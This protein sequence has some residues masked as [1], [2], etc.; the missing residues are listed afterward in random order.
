M[1]ILCPTAITTRFNGPT[2]TRRGRVTA[3]CE[4]SRVTVPWKHELSAA[5]NH[6][7]AA[8]KLAKKLGWSGHWY[9]GNLPDRYVWVRLL[10]SLAG[11]G[12]MKPAFIIEEETS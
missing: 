2:N 7:W 6:A 4:R 9:G 1:V 10:P 12:P 5:E 3:T 8:R 11:Q